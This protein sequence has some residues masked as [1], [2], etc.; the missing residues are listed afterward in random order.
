[1]A[2]T[3]SHHENKRYHLGAVLRVKNESNWLK[4]TGGFLSA[5]M[6]SGAPRGGGC[7]GECARH[8]G[9]P[10]G[11]SGC[12]VLFAASSVPVLLAS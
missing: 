5:S 11:V 1:M 12:S 10:S 3:Y 2:P 8:Q 4:Q 9:G 7:A 6:T